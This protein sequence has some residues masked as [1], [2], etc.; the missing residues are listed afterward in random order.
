LIY[1]EFVIFAGLSDIGL[2]RQNN[3]DVW[4]ALPEIGLFALAD[5][6][7]GHRA[8]EVAAKDAIEG[9]TYYLKKQNTNDLNTLRS[10]IEYANQQVYEKGSSLE[11]CRGMGTTLCCLQWTKDEIIYAHV[12]DSRI[13]RYRD[14]KLEQLTHDHS[15]LAQ[16]LAQGN[17]PKDTD[18]PIPYKNII[19]RSV[20]TSK[21]ANPEICTT[22]HKPGDLFI[23]CS[24]GLS[25]VLIP[26]DIEQIITRS[27]TLDLMAS[28][29]IEKAKIKGSNDNITVLI[30][31]FESQPESAL[32]KNLFR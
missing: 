11:A 23:L 21:K 29:L 2:T 3:E 17:N 26:T 22:T 15:L 8:G 19:T 5:G 10:A 9:L 24:D 20:G 30:V 28:R 25:D 14:Q 12:G 31:Q 6:M 7:G 4:V 16:W 1:E 18:K 32:G 13:Y 27:E